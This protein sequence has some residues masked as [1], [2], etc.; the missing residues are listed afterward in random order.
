MMKNNRFFLLGVIVLISLFALWGCPKKSQ[1]STSPETPKSTAPVAEPG[2]PGEPKNEQGEKPMTK[3]ES[4]ERAAA[5]AAAAGLQPIYFDFD[6]SFVRND[7]KA[8]MKANAEWLKANPRVK[9]RIEGNADE[10]GTKEYNQALGQRRA[11]SAKKYLVDLGI[12]ANRISLISYGKEKPVCNEATE[13][14][15]QKNRRDDFIGVT[16]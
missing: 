7:A 4:M 6:Q 11:T 10:R 12:S 16:E 3:E 5:A 14:C 15:W 1:V 9:I 2:A 13:G 8:V